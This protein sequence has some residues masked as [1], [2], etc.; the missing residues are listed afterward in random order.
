MMSCCGMGISPRLWRQAHR[1][2]EHTIYSVFTMVVA[3]EGGGGG[4]QLLT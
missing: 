4:L 3:A 2:K 1:E